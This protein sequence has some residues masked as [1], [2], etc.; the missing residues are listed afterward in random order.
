MQR[1]Y[2]TINLIIMKKTIL[3]VLLG[4]IT[5]GI[6]PAKAQLDLGLVAGMNLNKADLNKGP[7]NFHS[8]N[9]CG[10]Y[11]GPKLEV[12]LPLAGIGVDI[13]ALY[14]QRN[15]NGEA[16][17]MEKTTK[18]NT[19][20]IPLN[21]RCQFGLKSLVAAYIATGPQFG[22]NV[23]TKSMWRASEYKI[24]NSILTWNI[25]AGVKVLKH[26]EVGVGY[27]IA[28]SKFAKYTGTQQ[29]MK[30]NTFQAHLGYFF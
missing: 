27:N 9:R 5:L 4:L 28:L 11:V 2:S 17:G 8:S 26:L 29:S 6:T 12:T 24:Q 23:G 18:L 3:I 22:F 21:L 30:T 10:W 16:D 1:K 25:G 13:A 14:S 19:I 15:I 7:K 20:E